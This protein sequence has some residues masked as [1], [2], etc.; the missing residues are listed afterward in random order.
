VKKYFIAVVFLLGKICWSQEVLHLTNGSN[1]TV[2]NGAS[3]YLKGGLTLDNGS[4]LINN[5]TT[6]L[7]NNS[8]ANQSDWRDNSF[9]GAL[10]GNG[11]VVF[12]SDHA[13]QYWGPTHFYNVQINTTSLTANNNFTIDNQINLIQGKINTA[14]NYVF[15][16]NSNASSLLNDPGNIRYTNSWINGNFRRLITT[17][18]A[19]YDFPVGNASRSNLLQFVNNNI[20]GTN[21]LTA[22]FGPKPGTDQD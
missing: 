16:A 8:L 5:G 1:V 17:N 9:I 22:S 12:N 10:G 2:Q 13:H 15:L 20:V 14:T 7:K 11:L 3:L 18:T 4:L 19:V 6:W 21:Y